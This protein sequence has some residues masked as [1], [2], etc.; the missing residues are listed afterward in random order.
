VAIG[1]FLALFAVCAFLSTA[2]RSG[3]DK[4]DAW[5]MSQEFVKDQLKAPSTASFPS[6]SE[7]YVTDFGGG[8]FRVNGYV[9]AEN[10][11]GAKLR[12]RFTCTLNSQDGEHWHLED[13]NVE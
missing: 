13:I 12:S 9:D 1:L 2:K 5:L 8:R 3:P 7:S 4:L 11:F 6:Y 10:S